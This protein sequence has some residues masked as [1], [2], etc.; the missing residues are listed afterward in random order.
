MNFE[1]KNILE[2]D[3]ETYMFR[4]YAEFKRFT[5]ED[6]SVFCSTVLNYYVSNTVLE[7]S[8]KKEAAYYL[9]TLYNKGIGNR[10]T[11]E[12]LQL[13]AHTIASSEEVDFS[14]VRRLFG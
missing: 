2:R 9:V 5:L 6:L 11:E 7:L 13:I 10:I 14:V 1:L 3:F 4:F 12:H 8:K